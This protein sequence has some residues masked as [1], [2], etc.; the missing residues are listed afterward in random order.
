[1]NAKRISATEND[2]ASTGNLA[3]W[4]CVIGLAFG[5][6]IPDTSP[7][8]E[9]PVV[10][11]DKKKGAELVRSFR[12][13]LVIVEGKSGRGSAFIGII[14]GRKFL[15]TNAHVIAGI[16]EPHF[17]SLDNAPVSLDSAA[18]VAVGHDIV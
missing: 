6:M 7:G 16:K 14:K 13:D 9:K 18:A 10:A 4:L 5:A 17:K 12:S 1:M 3:G 11:A 2:R 15:I 8:A